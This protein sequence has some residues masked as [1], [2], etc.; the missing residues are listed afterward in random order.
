MPRAATSR[1]R[2]AQVRDRADRVG[3]PLEPGGRRGRPSAEDAPPLRARARLRSR[4]RRPP[5]RPA[6]RSRPSARRR[7]TARR[8]VEHP[9]ARRRRPVRLVTT[10]RCEA[11][12][13]PPAL[14]PPPTARNAGTSSLVTSP[15]SS[16]NS[17]TI[18]HR[19]AISSGV[20]I[21]TVST[22]RRRRTVP[23]RVPV[24]RVVAGVAPEPR[25]A[26]AP[27]APASRSLR[28]SWAYS[29][30][31]PWRACSPATTV[32]FCQIPSRA[33]RRRPA[34]AAPR[35]RLPSRLS[36]RTRSSVPVGR[37]ARREGR[38]AHGATAVAVPDREHHQRHLGV[39]GEEA[40]PFPR[41]ADDPVD[42][43]QDARSLD[44]G[45]PQQVDD[46]LVSRPARNS[47]PPPRYTES[48]GWGRAPR[49]RRSPQP[50]PSRTGADAPA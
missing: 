44:S 31:P 2:F 19:R 28:T 50:P 46:G 35:A 36:T 22:G 14:A 43:E 6:G 13:R 15:V 18:G 33:R 1:R 12:R 11:R 30:W 4:R 9:R 20:S 45:L 48:F 27:P 40:R 41:A 47:P 39:P 16:V 42:A 29:R 8:R 26:V 5:P 3:V 37:R 7:R 34:G 21:A 17:S 49:R 32:S 10:G 25:S 24:G 23:E 38:R